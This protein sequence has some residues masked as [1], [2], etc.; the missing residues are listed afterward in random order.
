MVTVD[1]SESGEVLRL[2][3][4][5]K[6]SVQSLRSLPKGMGAERKPQDRQGMHGSQ[7]GYGLEMPEY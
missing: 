3:E 7:A 2:R 5:V 4:P 6:F 1:I